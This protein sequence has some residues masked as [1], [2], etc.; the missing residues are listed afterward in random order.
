MGV[1]QLFHH[2]NIVELD[3]EILIHRL[4]RA[5][6][7]DVVLELHRDLVVN[8]GLEEAGLS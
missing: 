6:D 7:G 8:E 1:F 5:A 3:V 4:Q 2:L